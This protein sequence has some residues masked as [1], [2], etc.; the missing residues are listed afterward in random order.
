MKP[1]LLHIIV[2]SL[3]TSAAWAAAPLDPVPS[4]GGKLPSGLHSDQASWQ[5]F[6]RIVAPV[7][8]TQAQFETWASDLDVYTDTPRW[9]TRDQSAEKKLQASQ[10]HRGKSPHASRIA[11]TIDDES[12]AQVGNAVAGNF[13]VKAIGQGPSAT[14]GIVQPCFGEE[15]RRNRPSYDYLVGNKLNTQ[16]GLAAAY[17]RATKPVKRGATPWRVSLPVDSVEVKA[18]WIP[19]PTLI[20]WLG[21]N[22]VAMNTA[23]VK[24]KYYTTTSKGDLYALV[25]LHVSSKEIPNWVWATFEHENNPGR[26]DTMGCFDS[27][28]AVNAA[29]A[30]VKKDNGQYGSCTKLPA[31]KAMFKAKNLSGVWDSYCLKSSQIDYVAKN[32]APLMLGD[33]FTERVAANV[34]INQSSCLACHA[35][36]AINKDGT[37]FMTLLNSNPMG[38]LPLPKDA[39]AMDFI[40]GGVRFQ[41]TSKKAAP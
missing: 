15:V 10:L 30:P 17:A 14:Q 9:P 31:L 39:V 12:C 22:G 27:F 7:S 1:H 8:P 11:P 23:Q 26:C 37:A 18:D 19:T 41:P 33:S 29:I 24:Q 5:H 21:K 3:L 4:R 35:G 6:V 2:L 28:G 32:G 25:S 38:K 36:A 40:W 20:E 16:K 13:P 34:P